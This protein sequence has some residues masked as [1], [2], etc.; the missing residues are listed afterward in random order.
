MT[1]TATISSFDSSFK[2]SCAG[3]KRTRSRSCTFEPPLGTKGTV[4]SKPPSNMPKPP[5]TPTGLGG[6]SWSGC[7]RS[8]RAGE[9]TPYSTGWNGSRTR[10]GSS[11]IRPSPHTAPSSSAC[12]AAPETPSVGRPLLSKT[13]SP[14]TF[15]NGDTTD[16][17]L[18]FMRA[19]LCRHG[20]PQMRRDARAALDGLSPASVHR[21]AMLHVEGISYLVEGDPLKADPILAHAVDVAAASDALPAVALTLAARGI[22]AI[23][24]NDWA[25]AET[26]VDEALAI[27][28]QWPFRQLLDQRPRLRLRSPDRGQSWRTRS[29][30]AKCA[31]NAARLRPL[32]TS[33]LPVVSVK[34]LLELGRAYLALGDS[35]GVVAVLRQAQDILQQRPDLGLLPQQAA[36]LRTELNAGHVHISGASSLTA[37]ELRLLPL[38][39]THLTLEEISERLYVSRNTVKTQ[40]ASVYRKFGVNSR[41]EAVIRIH[42]LGLLT[43][44]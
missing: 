23:D 21:W 5:T 16:G 7:N 15:P 30:P 39:Y 14:G 6:L 1:G 3:E 25:A 36:E 26:L 10:V 9:S 34:A 27:L 41:R 4:D 32:L 11:T 29:R 18:F 24:R 19:V 13:A 28:S 31:A 44:T 40:A 43:H 12:S 38:L 8:G 33:A 17:T 37:A 42:D 2:L 20:V 22:A 35:N